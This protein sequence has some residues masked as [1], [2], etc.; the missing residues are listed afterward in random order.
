MQQPE[1]ETEEILV[2]GYMWLIDDVVLVVLLSVVI[3]E[4]HLEV[5]IPEKPHLDVV[6]LVVDEQIDF[7]LFRE[8]LVEVEFDEMVYIQDL[9][10]L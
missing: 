7:H 2:L 9:T 8:A 10:E 6:E 1:D 4:E 3:S 5:D